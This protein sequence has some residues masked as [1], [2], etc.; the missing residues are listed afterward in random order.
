MRPGSN[1]IEEYKQ[2]K[3]GNPLL[4]REDLSRLIND[5]WEALSPGDKELLKWI[6]VFFRKPTPGKFM[7][8]I[9]MP[10]GFATSE[11]LRAIADL[12]RRI[13]NGVL[14]ITTRQQ[15]EL[16]GFTLDTVPVIWEKLRGVDLHS[17]QTGMDNV[18]NI[19]G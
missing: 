11:Q 12:S 17:L 6:G 5:G 1:P 19:H 16:R 7:M 13:G 9:R 10:N 2:T 14:D 18:R 8:R 3:H 4:I 15:I